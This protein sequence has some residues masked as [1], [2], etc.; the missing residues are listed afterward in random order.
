MLA[1]DA[2]WILAVAACLALACDDDPKDLRGT[3]DAALPDA[4]ATAISCDARPV[5][6]RYEIAE[7]S[8]GA[9][10]SANAFAGIV[11]GDIY[12]LRAGG[13]T[14]V[15][16]ELFTGPAAASPNCLFLLA[17]PNGDAV[18]GREHSLDSVNFAGGPND[19]GPRWQQ[20]TP[21]VL[22]IVRREG[23]VFEAKFSALLEPNSNPEFWQGAEGSYRLSATVSTNCYDHKI[24][25][26]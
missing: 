26:P 25:G 3:A 5:F 13:V 17:S 10:P 22:Q 7:K 9:N 23:P 19:C 14:S 4:N 2:T 12:T 24:P 8:A 20:R 18:T 16:I 11:V 15:A 6:L 21:S 1:R